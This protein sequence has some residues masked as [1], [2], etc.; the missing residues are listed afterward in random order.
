MH[1]KVPTGL[2]PIGFVPMDQTVPKG[3]KSTEF[4]SYRNPEQ[5]L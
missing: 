3:K 4:Q 1:Y 2:I 5:I